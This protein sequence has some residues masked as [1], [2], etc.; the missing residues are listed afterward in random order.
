MIDG[1]IKPDI[2]IPGKSAYEDKSYPREKL[3]VIGV[4]RTCKD[5]WRQVLNE[6]ESIP[7]KHI[8]TLQEGISENQLGEMHRKEV[9]LI[10]PKSVQKKFYPS[11]KRGGMTIL[12]VEAFLA[13]V[14]ALV[15]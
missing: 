5:R 13:E 1:R 7:H 12:T 6:A 3:C 11:A 4:K 10:V 2:L 9:T 8:L 14:R 15:A